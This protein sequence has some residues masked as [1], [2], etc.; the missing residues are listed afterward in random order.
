MHKVT[1]MS[2]FVSLV[3][4]G[5]PKHLNQRESV[6]MAELTGQVKN[7]ERLGVVRVSKVASPK[8]S[9]P[10]AVTPSSKVKPEP[11]KKD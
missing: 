5:E 8:P 4:D 10:K 1:C 3:V 7:L 9:Q 2:R 11:T 6:Q